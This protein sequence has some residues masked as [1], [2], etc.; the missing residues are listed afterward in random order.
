MVI[1]LA[2]YPIVA[3]AVCI[4]LDRLAPLGLVA[5]VTSSP[6]FLALLCAAALCSVLAAAARNRGSTVL[7][8]A[9]LF[10]FIGALILAIGYLIDPVVPQDALWV[11]EIFETVALVPLLAFVFYAASPLRLVMLTRAQRRML[12]AVAILLVLAAAAAAL[13]PW[14]VR[15]GP[16]PRFAAQNGLHLAQTVLDILFLEPVALV[17]VV[18]GISRGSSPYFLLGV[19]LL[20]LLPED[21]IGTFGLLQL[22]ERWDQYFHLLFVASQLYIFNG[23]LYAAARPPNTA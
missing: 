17:L 14:L 3:A 18:L 22:T 4:L 21:V 15:P 11:E 12:A 2:L 16:R 7:L 1:V 23:A 6:L 19:G 9:W 5:A 20:I 8:S 13:L 10:F